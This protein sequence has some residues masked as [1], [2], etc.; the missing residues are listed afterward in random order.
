MDAKNVQELVDR[1]AIRDCMYLYCRGVDRADENALRRSYW[2]EA[3]ESHG[4]YKGSSEGF[5]KYAVDVFKTKPRNIHLV[6]NILIE[7]RSQTEAAVES[8][9]TALQRGADSQGGVRQYLIVGRYC[10][11]FEKRGTEWRVIERVVAYDWLEE[12]KPSEET[13][14]MRFGPRLPIGGACPDDPVYRLLAG[15]KLV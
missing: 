12:Q 13:E 6:S 2:P 5:I 14:E 8:Y 1:E 11:R 4:A 3:Q 10:D 15:K 9:F 7:F